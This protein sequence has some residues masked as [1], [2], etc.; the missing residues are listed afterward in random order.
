M[1]NFVKKRNTKMNAY[2]IQKEFGEEG[3]ISREDFIAKEKE[4]VANKFKEGLNVSFLSCFEQN[5]F[6]SFID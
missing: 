5:E 6:R 1:T 2:L 4:V 3:T